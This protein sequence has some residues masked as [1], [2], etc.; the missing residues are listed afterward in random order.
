MYF[1]FQRLPHR[2]GEAQ[3]R[4]NGVPVIPSPAS[5]LASSCMAAGRMVRSVHVALFCSWWCF[6]CCKI[7]CCKRHTLPAPPASL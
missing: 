1:L 3:E 6:I 4:G 2:F 7:L 5:A